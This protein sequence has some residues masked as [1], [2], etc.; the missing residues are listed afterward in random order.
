MTQPTFASHHIVV[1]D[2]KNEFWEGAIIEAQVA[3]SLRARRVVTLPIEP[4]LVR[5][6][7]LGGYFKRSWGS[8]YPLGGASPKMCCPMIIYVSKSAGEQLQ[9][10]NWVAR[11]VP[12]DE[13]VAKA[14][15]SG[16]LKL[17]GWIQ[18][19]ADSGQPGANSGGFSIRHD[20]RR[21]V[22]QLPNMPGTGFGALDEDGAWTIYGGGTMVAPQDMMFACGL[23]SQIVGAKVAWSAITQSL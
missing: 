6:N 7:A 23:W 8:G 4:K 12:E 9:S 19:A 18:L 13:D 3:L 14:V 5:L 10:L 20:T 21:G 11:V 17:K 15:R 16:E 2:P 22:E 1:H